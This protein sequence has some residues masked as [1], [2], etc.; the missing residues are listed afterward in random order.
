MNYLYLL[1][2]I[3]GIAAVVIVVTVLRNRKH[4]SAS[5][6]VVSIK[7]HAHKKATTGTQKC[8]YCKHPSKN[9]T[10]Y[11]EHNGTV[12]GLCSNCKSIAERKDM[13]PI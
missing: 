2:I 6:K 10:F 3:I 11:A 1:L 8:S 13:L 4:S 5:S 9:L 7:S 12:V